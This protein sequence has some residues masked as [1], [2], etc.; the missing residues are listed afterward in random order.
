MDTQGFVDDGSSKPKR[1]VLGRV[2]EPGNLQIRQ[3]RGLCVGYCIRRAIV[4]YYSGEL[5]TELVL[6]SRRPS[7]VVQDRSEGN[8]KYVV[9]GHT[10]AVLVNGFLYQ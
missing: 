4:R 10:K 7:N 5:T 1:L 2:S 3:L 9:T 6:D 8:S